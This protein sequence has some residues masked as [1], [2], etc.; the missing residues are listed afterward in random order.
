MTGAN[1]NQELENSEESTLEKLDKIAT[2]VSTTIEETFNELDAKA[3]G[4]FG[5]KTAGKI[6][7]SHFSK[8]VEIA[9]IAN[10]YEE[11][12]ATGVINEIGAIASGALAGA[13]AATVIPPK[14]N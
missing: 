9:Q 2:V 12:G 3:G 8:P 1:D 10:A 14:N 7:A 5:I 13:E 11:N 4:N 6:V